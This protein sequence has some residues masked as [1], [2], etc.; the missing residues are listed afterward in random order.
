MIVMDNELFVE[1]FLQELDFQRLK[2]SFKNNLS[3][4]LNGNMR[5]LEHF[6]EHERSKYL[7]KD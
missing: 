2:I 7:Q 3:I 1:F 6:V 4:S 5:M